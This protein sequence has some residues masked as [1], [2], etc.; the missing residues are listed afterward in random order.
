M[1]FDV[2]LH[3]ICIIVSGTNLALVGIGVFLTAKLSVIAFFCG[4]LWRHHQDNAIF[5]LG[6]H[7][8]NVSNDILRG[9]YI[10]VYLFISKA[11]K[12]GVDFR[13]FA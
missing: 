6:V 13:K 7:F 1:S 9:V 5:E 10:I 8:G 4:L 11:T 3:E 2:D 12:V